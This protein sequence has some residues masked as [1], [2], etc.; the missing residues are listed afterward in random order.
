MKFTKAQH[1]MEQIWAAI[2]TRQLSLTARAEGD[3]PLT[4]SAL[5][6]QLSLSTATAR[7]GLHL[8]A[9]EGRVL[10]QPHLGYR[11]TPLSQADWQ[12]LIQALKGLFGAFI[13]SFPSKLNEQTALQVLGLIHSIQHLPAKDSADITTMT[14]WHL[15]L[16]TQL[17][18]GINPYLQKA[19][20]PVIAQHQRYLT[21]PDVKIDWLAQWQQ[22]F[23]IVRG[24]VSPCPQAYT[25]RY[26][27]YW[28]SLNQ[29]L[30]DQLTALTSGQFL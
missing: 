3:Y 19:L 21:H 10:Y 15:T 11:L 30:D 6:E 1:A 18:C 20:M 23:P 2:L 29:H 22:L 27:Q 13:D 9:V 16:H 26:Q 12:A 14:Y 5:C 28:Q 24:L 4:V 17:L 7:D 8:L 25:Q